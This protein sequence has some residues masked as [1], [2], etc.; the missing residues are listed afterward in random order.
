MSAAA[1]EVC[2]HVIVDLTTRFSF[3]GHLQIAQLFDKSQFPIFRSTFPAE[4]VQ[5][6]REYYPMVD[7][8]NLKSQL[9]IFY[10]REDINNYNGLLGL[11]NFLDDTNLKKTFTEVYKLAEIL[12]T[13]PMTT[14]E[15]ERCF[16]TLSHIK[17]HLRSTMC[18]D[19]LNSLSFMHIE[20]DLVY[21]TPNFV[22][23]VMEK[24]ITSKNRRM[25]F[26]YKYVSWD[27]LWDIP[28]YWPW[29]WPWEWSW[30][31]P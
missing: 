10:I 11:L 25:D 30:G 5:L 1:K 27:R 28:W 2:D 9:K 17:D 16:S 6:V 8:L 29:K 21:S 3:T 12:V 13:I 18:P 19:R 31:K 4:I 15:G 22:D 20:T 7:V 14:A 24:F 26:N 23:R